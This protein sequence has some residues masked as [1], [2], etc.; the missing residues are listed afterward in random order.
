[1]ALRVGL[2][3]LDNSHPLVDVRNIRRLVPDIEIVVAAEPH[4]PRLAKLRDEAG[5]VTLVDT[6]QLFAERPDILVVTLRPTR[7]IAVAD[8]LAE[9]GIPAFVNR[10]LVV[11]AEQ[12]ARLP[13]SFLTARNLMSDSVLR[14]APETRRMAAW[15]AARGLDDIEVHVTHGIEHWRAS[16]NAWQAE[17]G[18]GG[19]PMG[20]LAYHGVELVAAVAGSPPQLDAVESDQPGVLAAQVRWPSG[21]LGTIQ[22]SVGSPEMYKIQVTCGAAKAS[23]VLDGST[24]DSFGYQAAMAAFL[25]FRH[26]DRT[27]PWSATL[28]GIRVA[29]EAWEAVEAQPHLADTLRAPPITSV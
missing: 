29:V 20:A 12:F 7:L 10:P 24:E 19:G 6:A 26:G 4:H 22:L 3:G 25:Q 2:L 11:R 23:A 21:T 5:P 14:H 15:A 8:M 18:E 27:R 13:E 28:D 17:P 1:M 9:S 16:E